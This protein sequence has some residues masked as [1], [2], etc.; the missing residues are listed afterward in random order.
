MSFKALPPV[1]FVHSKY[2]GIQLS[3]SAVR[4][5]KGGVIVSH[6]MTGFLTQVFIMLL[7]VDI[8]P[9]GCF[10]DFLE[11]LQD[12]ICVLKFVML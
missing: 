11:P 5:G 4:P 7:M 3:L 10:C 1:V 9:P 12:R 6:K 8:P 2:M